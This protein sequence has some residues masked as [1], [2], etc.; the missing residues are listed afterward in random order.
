MLRNATRRAAA[1][2]KAGVFL[3]GLATVVGM[4][5]GLVASA[6]GGNGIGD[7]FE[8]GKKNTVDKSSKLQGSSPKPTLKLKNGEGSTLQLDPAPAMAPIT[9]SSDEVASGLNADRVDGASRSDLL[10]SST[11]TNESPVEAGTDLGDGTFTA[12]VA[13]NAGDKVLS[14]GPANVNPT[15]YI[16]E[17]FPAPGATTTAWKVRINK[18]AAADNWSVVALCSDQP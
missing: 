17:S 14:G 1:V 11:Y 12:E 2:G 9:T 6:L 8:L 18:N 13:C 15:S 4:S 10:S 3:V 5:A 16:V 7:V